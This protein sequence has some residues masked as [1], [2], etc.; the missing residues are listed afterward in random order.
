MYIGMNVSRLCSNVRMWTLALGGVSCVLMGAAESA[1]LWNADSE[2]TQ[3]HMEIGRMKA[4]RQQL[5][6]AQ[7][8]LP[9]SIN[10][11]SL[12][13][14]FTLPAPSHVYLS[15]TSN[16]SPRSTL[17]NCD[18][19]TSLS[20]KAD[21]KSNAN[22]D[23]IDFQRPLPPIQAKTQES[24]RQ[25]KTSIGKH[26]KVDKD[27][28][29]MST[30]SVPSSTTVTG[31]GTGSSSANRRSV[32]TS[33]RLWDKKKLDFQAGNSYVKLHTVL[34]KSPA[35][36]ASHVMEDS[37]DINDDDDVSDEDED[38]NLHLSDA[39]FQHRSNGNINA[40]GNSNSLGKPVSSSP[41]EAASDA[42]A[43][44]D[45]DHIS[46]ATGIRH[47][48]KLRDDNQPLHE[49]FDGNM[50]FLTLHRAITEPESFSDESEKTRRVLF[51]MS[52][53]IT[54]IVTNF[55]AECVMD[56]G[57]LLRPL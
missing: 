36:F 45:V 33:P 26:V 24:L 22:V 49:K 35:P 13:F 53:A 23:N 16:P 5:K 37:R 7:R 38:M 11:S 25:R 29:H 56:V 30:L 28:L 43:E 9:Q 54:L 57:A 27:A 6:L 42:E 20:L 2:R 12:P 15:Y 32:P 4:A 41:S 55:L 8:S 40:N 47:I 10:L 48:D 3:R 34:D 39:D 44:G 1:L 50:S 52:C 31:T 18:S 17:L 46:P 14:S 21:M 19:E 51:H